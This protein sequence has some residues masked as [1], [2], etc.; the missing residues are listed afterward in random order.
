MSLS[1]TSLAAN[2]ASF[3]L[4]RTRAARKILKMG[5]RENFIFAVLLVEDYIVFGDVSFV[6]GVFLVREWCSIYLSCRLF[7]EMA[8]YLTD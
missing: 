4:T 2:W 7:S 6:S 5:N 8:Q 3:A 1:V